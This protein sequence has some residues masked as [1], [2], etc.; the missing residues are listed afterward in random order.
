[1][2]VVEHLVDRNELAGVGRHASHAAG[3]AGVHAAR[4]LVMRFVVQDFL[5]LPE[6]ESKNFNLLS[7]SKKQFLVSAGIDLKTS[8]PSVSVSAFNMKK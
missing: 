1:M 4:H 3:Q 6:Y 8:V 5:A 7:S 2:V